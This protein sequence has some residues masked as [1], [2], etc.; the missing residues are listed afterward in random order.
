MAMN[1]FKYFFLEYLEYSHGIKSGLEAAARRMN[2]IEKISLRGPAGLFKLNGKHKICFGLLD[3]CNSNISN[4][5]IDIITFHRKGNNSSIDILVETEHLLQEFREKYPNLDL[6]YANTEADPSSGWSTNV[7]SYADVHYAHTIVSIVLQHWNAFLKGSLKNLDSISHDNSF[8]SYHPFE[9]EQ[10]TMLSRFIMNETQS[11]P[12]YFIQKPVYAALGMLS[13]L[14]NFATEMQTRK[15]I[16]YIISIGNL[17]AAVLLLSNED[18]N[19]RIKINL[20]WKFSTN[21]SFGYFAEFLDQKRTNPYSVWT[22]YNRPAYPNDTVLNE[23]LH[24][25][26]NSFNI[27]I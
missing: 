16:S 9:F 24:A 1:E 5:P 25:Q 2:P 26:V 22:H 18:N 14:A 4:C 11:K 6:P 27:I 21:S 3:H 15:N 8:L 12:T 23:M 19:Q 20:N 10:R 17:Y 13:S 7:T